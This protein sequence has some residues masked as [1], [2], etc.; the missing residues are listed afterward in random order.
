MSDRCPGSGHPS[1]KPDK[2]TAAAD[3]RGVRVWPPPAASRLAAEVCTA[4]GHHRAC[5]RIVLHRRVI[6]EGS[7]TT[8][9]SRS[10]SHR[11]SV[12]QRARLNDAVSK[13]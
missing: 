8:S 2:L 3:R 5:E 4:D 6:P 11:R 12:T 1:S 9:G 7:S 10:G 13:A